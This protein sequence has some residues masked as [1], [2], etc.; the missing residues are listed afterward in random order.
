MSDPVIT[1]PLRIDTL[2]KARACGYSIWI[3]CDTF[4]CWRHRR[5]D[6]GALADRLGPGHGCLAVDLAP[7]FHCS[8]CRAAG[9]ADRNLSFTLHPATN[10]AG[11]ARTAER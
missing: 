2:G 1:Y 5:I 4:G 8:D 10:Q 11:W 6:L 9:R 3:H 7:R